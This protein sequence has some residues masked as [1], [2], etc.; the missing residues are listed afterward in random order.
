MILRRFMQHIREQNWFAVSIDVIV[1]VGSV[2]LAT[3]LSS[4]LDTRRAEQDLIASMRNLHK[5]FA[6]EMLWSESAINWQKRVMAGLRDAIAILD[7][8]EPGGIDLDRVHWALRVGMSPPPGLNFQATLGELRDSGELRRIPYE[9][10]SSILIEILGSK[11]SL[12]WYYERDMRGANEQPLQYSFIRRDL[13]VDVEQGMWG[14]AL[15]VSVDWERAREDADFRFRLLQAHSVFASNTM[16]MEGTQG[17]L[18]EAVSI[19]KD[20]GFEPSSDWWSDNRER[21][22]KRR[23][24]WTGELDTDGAE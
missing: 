7:G 16:N 24:A 21:V 13:N 15:I 9:N 3:Q 4:A 12:L 17:L 6:R 11:E 2:F 14:A 5:E 10:L 1:V 22:M 20:L 8:E 18:V 23:D 19:L